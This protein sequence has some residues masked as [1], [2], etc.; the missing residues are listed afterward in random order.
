MDRETDCLLAYTRTPVPD[1]YA[2]DLAYSVHLALG[3]RG[4]PYTCL[5]RNYGILF[6]E[7]R[8][9]AD[10][11]IVPLSAI[12]PCLFRTAD[13]GIG[14]A[15]VRVRT[16]G[17]DDAALRGT[18]LVWTLEAD[19][20]FSAGRL[21]DLHTDTV[22]SSV[23]IEYDAGAQTYRIR[24][25]DRDGKF[26]L[27]TL[28]RL[29][30]DAS[31]AEPCG[32][33]GAEP[34]SVIP[35]TPEECEAIRMRWT[36]VHQVGVRLPES[37]AAGSA[38][39][40]RAVRAELLYSDGSSTM[41]DIE[42]DLSPV[43][44]DVPGT[45][46]VTG[47]IRPV[48]QTFP[49]APGFA[50]PVIMLR[51]GRYC[52]IASND[53]TDTRGLYACA[54]DTLEGLFSPDNPMR[55]ILPVD[56]RR[57][58]IQNFWAPELHEIGGSLYILFAVSAEKNRIPQPQCHMMRLKPGGD[59]LD[60]ASWEDPVRVR[61]ADGSPLGTSGI[62][63]DM[64]CIKTPRASYLIWSGREHFTTPLDT[65][66]MLCIATTDPARPWILTSD[67]VVL[68]RPLFGW[69]NIERTINNEAPYPLVHAG[70]LWLA[71]S[72]GSAGAYSYAVGWLSADIG[73]DLMVRT[74]WRKTSAPALSYY[75]VPGIYGPGHNS[76][77]VDQS[78]DTMLVYH[79]GT[80]RQH[81]L[82]STGVRRVHFG[83]SGMPLLDL[84]AERDL[85]PALRDVAMD[86]VVRA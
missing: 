35:I 70:K 4:G 36:Q 30:A 71:Y 10:N 55:E 26:Y 43:R 47:R 82:R 6:A 54:S 66:S 67:P 52:F 78:G 44:F 76:F 37:V 16:D 81:Y 68:S 34:G 69:E 74:S 17:A 83:R 3:G 77:F 1:E 39:E 41:R 86:V 31:A 57:G 21:I 11:T 62:T 58:L 14:V 80:A 8:I 53:N 50:D 25:S 20:E 7:A 22:V 33:D 59:L 61:R 15:A 23:G 29:D 38:A 13:G 72:A 27:N 63:L 42:W 60:P 49:V 75:S 65:G 84:D 32:I 48:M 5:N 2:P 45:A 56:E 64:T 28:D 12:Q 79:G 9:S 73:A 46:R 18:I 24:W 51:D 85:D 40:A 19:G